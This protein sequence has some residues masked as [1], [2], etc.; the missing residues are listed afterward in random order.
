MKILELVLAQVTVGWVLAS[1]LALVVAAWLP[2]PFSTRM[3]V[4]CE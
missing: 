3:M 2:T 1:V 4:G